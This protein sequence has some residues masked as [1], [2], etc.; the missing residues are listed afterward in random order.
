MP[1]SDDVKIVVIVQCAIALE[2]CSGFNCSWAFYKKL[3]YFKDYSKD[4]MYI[5]FSCGGCPGRRVSRLISNLRKGALKKGNIDKHNIVVHLTACVVND[6]TE[7]KLAHFSVQHKNNLN[8]WQKFI[9]IISLLVSYGMV[10]VT[11][12][13]I[14]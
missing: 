1:L 2:R 8:C 6:D 14:V 3:N 5:P 11:A 10:L 13:T 12:M 4:V 9:L 7:T